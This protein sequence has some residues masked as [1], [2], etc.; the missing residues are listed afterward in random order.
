VGS[1]LDLAVA[2]RG[3]ARSRAAA[4]ALV[5]A[6]QVRVNGCVVLRPSTSVADSDQIAVR[7]DPY[8][9]RAAHK[10]AGVLAELDLD[11]TGFRALDAGAST[12]GF[13]QVLLAAGCREVIAVDVGH[14]QLADQIRTDPRV[15][16]YEHLNVREL[17]LEHVDQ[18]P[19][20]LLV[21]DLSFISLILVLTAL[22][23][24]VDPAGSLLVMVKPQ[25]EI[26]RERLGEGG[27]V[28]SPELHAEAVT[29]V[30]SAAAALGWHAHAVVPSRL[31]GPAGNREFFVLLTTTPATV[32]VDVA[33]CVATG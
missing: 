29:G 16:V 13:T 5:R 3:L 19:V 1:R 9:S 10:L 7:A 31:P 4:T 17:R 28:R 25:F 23:G 33:A 30:I 21:A 14:G 26:G 18:R 8:V 24:V 12:G 27:V 20:D 6:G 15:R 22:T 11:V 32:Q 2:E